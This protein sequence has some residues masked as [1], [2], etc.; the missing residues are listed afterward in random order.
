MVKDILRGATKVAVI[1]APF[2]C[3]VIGIW[4]DFVELIGRIERRLRGD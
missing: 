4:F 3:W 2:V 1:L